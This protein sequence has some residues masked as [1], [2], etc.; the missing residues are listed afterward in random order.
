MLAD[1]NKNGRRLSAEA[2]KI[3]FRVK[4]GGTGNAMRSIRKG[5]ARDGIGLKSESSAFLCSS[6]ELT[7]CGCERVMNY[8]PENVRLL[9]SDGIME[10]S[11]EGLTAATY[12]GREIKLSG[13]IDGIRLCGKTKRRSDAVGAFG[14]ESE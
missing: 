2:F 9:L 12:F 11:G 8:T 3:F 14:S 7:V 1:V 13:K 4:R 6:R 10:I 5:R